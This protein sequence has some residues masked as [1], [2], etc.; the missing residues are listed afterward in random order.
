MK[1]WRATSKIGHVSANSLKVDKPTDADKLGPQRV[2]I[3]HILLL[4]WSLIGH[5]G[6]FTWAHVDANGFKTYSTVCNEEGLK[7]WA[8]LRFELEEDLEAYHAWYDFF[9][10]KDIEV[11][12][13]LL[14]ASRVKVYLIPLT[15]G[16]TVCVRYLW[17]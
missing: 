6:A 14:K 11:L 4:A 1:A 5:G 15:R 9:F 16:K 10:Q 17:F 12:L 8:I 13:A 2:N 7:I 3:D